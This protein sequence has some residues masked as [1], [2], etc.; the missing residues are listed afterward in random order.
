MCPI[1]EPSAAL[2][3][4]RSVFTTLILSVP[5]Q[6]VSQLAC[7]SKS[8]NIVTTPSSLRICIWGD[9]NFFQIYNFNWCKPWIRTG[10]SLGGKEAQRGATPSLFWLLE[11]LM[12]FWRHHPNAAFTAF[13]LCGASWLCSDRRCPLLSWIYPWHHNGVGLAHPCGQCWT[14][15]STRQVG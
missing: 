14:R 13:Y 10:Y 7:R 11:H 5:K 12:S 15:F 6:T 3:V 9:L 2:L 1:S 8:R 4:D